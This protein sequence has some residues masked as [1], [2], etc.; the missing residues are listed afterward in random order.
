MLHVNEDMIV[1]AAESQV[2]GD[3]E[4]LVAYQRILHRDLMEMA[5]F[6][7][8]MF[9]KTQHSALLTAIEAGKKVRGVQR[10]KEQWIKSR[11]QVLEEEGVSAIMNKNATITTKVAKEPQRES[12][13]LALANQ[14]R[15]HEHVTE[16][17]RAAPK[18]KAP[19]VGP[20]P[21]NMLLT[22]QLAMAVVPPPL[23]VPQAS[24]EASARQPIRPSNAGN[25]PAKIALPPAHSMLNVLFAFPGPPSMMF[26]AQAAGLMAMPQW[27]PQVQT[28]FPARSV[29]PVRPPAK[30]SEF[31]RMCESCRKRHI[32]VRECRLVHQHTDPEWQPAQPSAA[33][34]RRRRKEHCNTEQVA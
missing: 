2:E 5:E 20:P 3:V 10:S 8:S 22:N 28:A 29:V 16:F 34:R 21:M 18:E 15:A 30:T 26:N 23:V 7:D 32:S 19:V 17:L 24:L 4:E 31:K 33:T 25:I 1:A 13:G 14:L 9:G 27:Q 12:E 11:D 6:I